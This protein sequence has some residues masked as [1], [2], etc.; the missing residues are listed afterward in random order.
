MVQSFN[1]MGVIMATKSASIQVA[2]YSAYQT[3]KHALKAR[4]TA[5]L[6]LFD[7]SDP[8]STPVDTHLCTDETRSPTPQTKE[9]DTYP[10]AKK[11]NECFECC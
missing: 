10:N 6:K 8:I 3:V 1:V 9:T 2:T 5:A 4:K 7:R 11:Q